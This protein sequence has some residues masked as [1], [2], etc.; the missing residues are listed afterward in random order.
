MTTSS[1]GT[2]PGNTSTRRRITIPASRPL[3]RYRTIDLVIPAMVG[4]AFGVVFMGWDVVYI[5]PSAAIGAVPLL[6]IL[7]GPW[8]L[9][10]V[11]GGLLVRRPGAALLTELIAAAVE[12]I[13]GTQWGW[14]TLIS[15]TLQGLGVELALA[16]F[17]WRRFGPGVAVLAGALAAAFEVVVYEWHAWYPD[18]TW[19][20]KLGYLCLFALS[21]AVV[22]GLGGWFIVRVLAKTGAV[23]AMPA[24]QEMLERR[25]R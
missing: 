22:A 24:G 4:V 7:G 20:W 25:A 18:W 1:I 21:G 16:L 15:G 13:P 19:A 5:A 11:V 10:G 9:A 14:T 6:G 23:R 12:A 3:L 2:S 17:L 8:L